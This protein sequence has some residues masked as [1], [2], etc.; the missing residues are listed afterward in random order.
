M[1]GVKKTNP[2][3]E[4]LPMRNLEQQTPR[5]AERRLRDEP[6]ARR[7]DTVTPRAARWLWP[8]RVALG[9]VT[10]VA[11]EPGAGTSLLLMNLASRVSRGRALPGSAL[12]PAI[13][14]DAAKAQSVVAK[15]EGAAIEPDLSRPD[16]EEPDDIG[17][18]RPGKA[19][20]HEAA[21]VVL[22]MRQSMEDAVVPR[23]TALDA[24]LKRIHDLGD[25]RD[26][27]EDEED[28]EDDEHDE[29][30][31]IRAFRADKDLEHLESL[32]ARTPAVKLVV[33]DPMELWLDERG[34]RMSYSSRETI[35][36]LGELARRCDVAIVAVARVP[37]KPGAND[38]RRWLDK[39]AGVEELAALFAV[40]RDRRRPCRRYLAALK[41]TL[42]EV[43]DAL[44]F[45][46]PGGQ[47]A[48]KRGGVSAAV[49]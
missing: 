31:T 15:A 38:M 32:L 10:L 6:A 12:P 27:N 1:P 8:G 3:A 48:W 2:F 29:K 22:I 25:V 43:E 13:P 36:Q 9:Q 39:L 19:V 47:V 20:P 49:V 5:S 16:K 18:G 24:D 11:G 37:D 21:D 45:E 42:A 14:H 30:P 35:R 41:N 28:G 46:T 26:H 44:A 34:Q 40:V 17:G 33:L 23:L 7:L 4:D